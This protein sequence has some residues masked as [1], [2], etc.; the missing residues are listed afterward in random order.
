MITNICVRSNLLPGRGYQGAFQH[1]TAYELYSISKRCPMLVN[2]GMFAPDGR[3]RWPNPERQGPQW[4]ARLFWGDR[5]VTMREG[6]RGEWAV[7]LAGGF[8]EEG[9]PR[10]VE[11][12]RD[13]EGVVELLCVLRLAQ[14]RPC[15][16]SP[17]ID[18]L[19]T[20]LIRRLKELEPSLTEAAI[21]TRV[22]EITTS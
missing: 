10:V 15:R 7:H 9:A 8:V 1:L 12:T 2:H 14:A 4:I 3:H 16:I 20:A 11:A 22:A 18:E 13:R 5:E 6:G 19:A 17:Q 21:E